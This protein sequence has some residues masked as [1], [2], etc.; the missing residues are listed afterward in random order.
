MFIKK[1]GKYIIPK[2]QYS[3]NCQIIAKNTHKSV[4]N[5]F[6]NIVV[7]YYYQ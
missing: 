1:K 3:R 5:R 6:Y 4:N 2:L 7:N